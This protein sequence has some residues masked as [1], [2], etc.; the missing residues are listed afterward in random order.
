MKALQRCRVA[1]LRAG[2]WLAVILAA[3]PVRA[4]QPQ[5]AAAPPQ[6]D[7]RWEAWLGCWEPVSGPVKVAGDTASTPLVC[8]IPVPGSVGVD[9]ATISGGKLVTR[10]RIEATGEQR[11]V[12]REGCSGWESARFSAQGQ[13]VF[14]TA[15]YTC[16][17]DIKRTTNELMAITPVGDWLDVRGASVR[18]LPEGVRVLRYRPASGSAAVPGD[19]A[20]ALQGNAM[21][22]STARDAAGAPP[23]L[24]DV[25]EASHA[26]APAI[27][28]AWV[29]EEGEAFQLDA[30]RLVQLQDA[31]VPDRVID[32][33]VAVSYPRVFAI[34]V[35]SHQGQRRAPEYGSVERPPVYGMGYASPWGC[36]SP[37]SWDCYS[38]YGW[39]YYSPFF[40]SPYG[41]YSPY[42][43]WSGY[44][45]Y[46]SGGIVVVSGGGGQVARHGR[47][48]IGKGYTQGTSG[49]GVRPERSRG[50]GSESPSSGS[51]SE[52]RGTDRSSGSSSSGSS[53]SGSSG[54]S[55]SGSSSS[56]SSSSGSSSTG[57]T[58]HPKP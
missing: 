47:M 1:G 50:S 55:S 34:D 18:G 16:P 54:S 20:W 37:Y 7:P 5:S 12:A 33:M 13:R 15:E 6:A 10:V 32:V 29:V 27:V 39:G 19:L 11:T 21:A 40:S 25:V 8:V 3:A 36:Y 28:E 43:Y 30:K 51:G 9:V 44:G 48:V 42:G 23:E 57:R 49:Q 22:I 41:Y 46:P 26:L 2:A 56:G 38:P 4:Q 31:G 17:G 24:E 45:F 35:S 53:T 14:L 52:R 58:A